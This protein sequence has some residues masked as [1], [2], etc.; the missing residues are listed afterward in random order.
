MADA[1]L[2][3]L[4]GESGSQGVMLIMYVYYMYNIFGPRF[5]SHE[6]GGALHQPLLLLV[7]VLNK[8]LKYIAIPEV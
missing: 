6:V 1:K 3:S 4:G 5:I 8:D 2:H 7:T